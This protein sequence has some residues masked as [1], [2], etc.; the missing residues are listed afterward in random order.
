MGLDQIHNEF[1]DADPS[2]LLF[3]HAVIWLGEDWSVIWIEGGRQGG[4]EGGRMTI[5][6]VIPLHIAEFCD[7]IIL[8]GTLVFQCV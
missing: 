4:K 3:L 1:R 8:V 2:H 7:R 6:S 5:L